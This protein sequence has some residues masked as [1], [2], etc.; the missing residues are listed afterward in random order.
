ML[1]PRRVSATMRGGSASR[2]VRQG[3]AMN[4]GK[5]TARRAWIRIGTSVQGLVLLVI[6]VLAVCVR[7]HSVPSAKSIHHP[8]AARSAVNTATTAPAGTPV[9][10]ST[11]VAAGDSEHPAPVTE[12]AWSSGDIVASLS[13]FYQTI[14]TVLIA[15]LGLLGVVSV[16]TLRFLSNATAEE[17]AHK[18]ASA[19]MQHALDTKKFYDKI[20]EAVEESGIRVQ[21]EDLAAQLDDVQGKPDV[22]PSIS[23]LNERMAQMEEELSQ[24]RAAANCA[25]AVA[26][27]TTGLRPAARTDGDEEDESADGHVV[28]PPEEP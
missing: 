10:A 7:A 20:D 28:V 2:S 22:S 6:L 16:L 21:L 23:A 19:A 25:P 26:G 13:S 4:N 17:T 14:I 15:L 18:A 9:P 27:D 24:L 8:P 11:G 3:S 1:R 5:G 12:D